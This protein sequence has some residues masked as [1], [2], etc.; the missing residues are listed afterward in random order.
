VSA[1]PTNDQGATT[2][3]APPSTR[4]ATWCTK[5]TFCSLAV[6]RGVIPSW[7]EQQTGV[8]W[9]TLKKHYA[10]YIPDQG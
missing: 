2:A 4:T 5:D 7:L 9:A 6:T 10:K 8:A 1:W 3:S